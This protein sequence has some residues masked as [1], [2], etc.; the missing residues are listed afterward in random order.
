[1]EEVQELCIAWHLYFHFRVFSCNSRHL[2]EKMVHLQY[3]DPQT[4]H[5]IRWWHFDLNN[6]IIWGDKNSWSPISSYRAGQGCVSPISPMGSQPR[7]QACVSSRGTMSDLLFPKV[8]GQLCP[9]RD[10]NCNGSCNYCFLVPTGPWAQSF[11]CSHIN[12]AVYK[13]RKHWVRCKH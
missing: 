2:F 12:G 13:E 1:M 4:P 9:R 3:L 5:V 6:E 7:G 10:Q 8:H 11:L